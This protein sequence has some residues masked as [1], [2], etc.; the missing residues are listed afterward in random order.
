VRSN[1]P[2]CAHI[3]R[4]DYKEEATMTDLSSAK[5]SALIIRF[6]AFFSYFYL[7][8]MLILIFEIFMRYVLN[9]PTQWVHETSIFLSAICFVFGGLYSASSNTNLRIVLVYDIV[10][11]DIRRW[12]DITIYSLCTLTTAAFSIATWYA[13]E[14]SFWTP[15]G[16]FRIVTSG[17]AWN[18]PYPSYLRAFLLLVLMAMTVQ[19]IIFVYQI[20]RGNRDV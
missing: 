19:F 11:K 1:T 9:S 5:F 14:K 4:I 17:S 16:E 8:I 20:F 3:Y 18:P 7:I 10:S 15:S 2:L 13:V 12:L 6:G